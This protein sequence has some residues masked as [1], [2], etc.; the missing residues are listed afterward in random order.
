MEVLIL[1]YGPQSISYKR[2]FPEKTQASYFLSSQKGPFYAFEFLSREP[3]S[4]NTLI[5]LTLNP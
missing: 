4:H 3:I 2:S 1:Q 5:T